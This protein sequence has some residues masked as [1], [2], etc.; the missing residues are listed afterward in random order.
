MACKNNPSANQPPARVSPKDPK[1]Y[2]EEKHDDLIKLIETDLTVGIQLNKCLTPRCFNV[3]CNKVIEQPVNLST[4]TQFY[5]N[6]DQRFI[7][8]SIQL[9][10]PF[11]SLLTLITY[12]CTR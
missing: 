6:S 12:A 3:N 11:F 1:F 9:N 5:I 4:L 8:N 2:L 7:E 10:K